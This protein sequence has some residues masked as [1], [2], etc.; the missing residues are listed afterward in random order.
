MRRLTSTILGAAVASLVLYSSVAQ[1]GVAQTPAAKAAS[2]PETTTASYG[3]W[4]VACSGVGSVHRCEAMH[5]IKDTKGQAAAVI[6][7]GRVTREAPLRLALRVPVNVAVNKPSVLKLGA[8]TINLPFHVCIAQGCFA[9]ITLSD[10]DQLARL[11]ALGQDVGGKVAWQDSSGQDGSIDVS[12]RGM[13]A[14]FEALN[15]SN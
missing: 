15:S 8:E 3:D 11:R 10:P 12:V 14:A 6:S 1:A 9:D 7:V 13:A 2:A 5:V 4:L